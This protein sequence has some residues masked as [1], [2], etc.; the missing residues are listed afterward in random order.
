[1]N[2]SRKTKMRNEKVDRNFI[3]SSTM[4]HEPFRS[5][6][7]FKL[8]PFLLLCFNNFTKLFAKKW[9]SKQTAEER[10]CPRPCKGTLRGDS[11]GEGR[12]ATA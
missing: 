5:D 6:I 7:P 3:H 9:T 2:L 10:V 1:M 4:I 11:G 8:V 12:G